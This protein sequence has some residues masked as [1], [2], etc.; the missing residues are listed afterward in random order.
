MKITIDLALLTHQYFKQLV[1][2]GDYDSIE[3]VAD[4]CF[5]D[6]LAK[7]YARETANTSTSYDQT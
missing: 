4:D 5:I 1:E 3:D 7:L 2:R 6:G